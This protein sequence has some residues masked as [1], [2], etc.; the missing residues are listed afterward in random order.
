MTINEISHFVYK[1]TGG[2][3]KQS[4]DQK[5][6]DIIKRCNNFH[7]KSLDKQYKEMLKNYEYLGYNMQILIG[8]KATISQ[9]VFTNDV[10]HKVVNE[11]SILCIA[12]DGNT[13]VL[14]PMYYLE[15]TIFDNIKFI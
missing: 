3:Y 2:R 15:S 7:T 8:F 9:R 11:A 13:S 5:V 1:H 6:N 4:E 10:L 14:K 12:H